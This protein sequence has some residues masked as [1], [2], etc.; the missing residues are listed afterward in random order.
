MQKEVSEQYVARLIRPFNARRS[1]KVGDTTATIYALPALEQA[2]LMTLSKLPY[3]IR[4]CWK[5]FY[6][7]WMVRLSLLMT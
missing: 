2:G 7:I 4:Y 5:T 1:L 3:S 6:A